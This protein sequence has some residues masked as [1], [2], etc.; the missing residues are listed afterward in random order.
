[1]WLQWPPVRTGS[2]ATLALIAAVLGGV[3]VLVVAKATGWVDGETTTKTVVVREGATPSGVGG[4]VVAAKPIV[5]NGF[6]PAQIYRSRSAGVVT[7]VSYFDDPSAPAASAGQGSGFVVA[8]DGTILTNAHVITTAG[9]G[10]PGKATAAGTIYVEFS[11]GDRVEA[12]VVGYDLL[13]DVGVIKGDPSLHP[14]EPGPPPGG[15]GGRC[16]WAARPVL[17]WGS[18][19]RRSAAPSG[20]WTP[21][22]S[23]SS[24]RSGARS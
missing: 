5:G 3:A 20:T 19:W 12:R 6:Q 4:P 14:L 10:Q 13:D 22:R 17:W 11:D 18:L 21:S 7:I 2:A 15:R 24:P 23:V 16:R 1:M 9:Q 8:T